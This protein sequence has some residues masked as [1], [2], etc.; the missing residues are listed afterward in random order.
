[1]TDR[2]LLDVRAPSKRFSGVLSPT[3]RSIPETRWRDPR[4]DRLPRNRRAGKTTAGIATRGPARERQR[5]H[6]LDGRRHH[7]RCR[8]TNAP[9]RVV[10][11]FQITRLF[12][13]SNVLDNV[14]W[15]S[16]GWAAAG[17]VAA[18]VSAEPGLFER[19]RS[20]LGGSAWRDKARVCLDQLCHGERR[21][22]E[23]GMTLASRAEPWSARRADG[24]AGPDERRA[25]ER[26]S[27]AFARTSTVGA[28]RAR[29]R[30]GCFASPIACACCGRPHHR[31]QRPTRLCALRRRR[32]DPCLLGRPGP[33]RG[34]RIIDDAH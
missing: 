12:K 31:P 4:T 2:L 19:A 26:S 21:A 13:T 30:R 22:L 18:P 28:D 24:W 1:V 32:R 7:P 15:R 20:V 3:T 8:R 25:M 33:A 34:R 23:V 27:N 6:R 14:T 9:A 5:Q 17:R 29:C 16:G 10:R 11:S